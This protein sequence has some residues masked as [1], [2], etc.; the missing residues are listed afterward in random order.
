M[1]RN[2]VCTFIFFR[3]ATIL[4]GDAIDSSHIFIMR[5]EI[6]PNPCALLLFN[7]RIMDIISSAANKT[8]SIFLS[9]L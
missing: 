4:R 6:P 3:I 9:I 8:L 1:H 2:D 5:M 7:E